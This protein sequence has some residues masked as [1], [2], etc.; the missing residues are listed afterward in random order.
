MMP[1]PSGIHC[2]SHKA[3]E[4]SFGDCYPFVL[5][6]RARV[7]LISPEAIPIT[8]FNCPGVTG[9][10]LYP[11]HHEVATPVPSPQH[12]TKSTTPLSTQAKNHFPS[13]S[14]LSHSAHP[15]RA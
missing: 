2:D 5:F 9:K 12:K 8:L 6:P 3:V 7:L 11:V 4:S 15:D 10:S 13:T 14:P 1:I